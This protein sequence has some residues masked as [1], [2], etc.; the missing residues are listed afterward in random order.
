MLIASVT[1]SP[2]GTNHQS[3][4]KRKPIYMLDVSEIMRICVIESNNIAQ[5]TSITFPRQVI[6]HLLL[7]LV[8]GILNIPIGMH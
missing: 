8:I 5:N 3:D 4:F 7:I 2:A 6:S 1:F